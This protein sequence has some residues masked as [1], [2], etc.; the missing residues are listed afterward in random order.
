M[1]ITDP[2]SLAQDD[3]KICWKT[4]ASTSRLLLFLVFEKSIFNGELWLHCS[5]IP[6]SWVLGLMYLCVCVCVVLLSV[7]VRSC[8]VWRK[9]DT[10]R[11]R[12]KKAVRV[13]DTRADAANEK[14]QWSRL[15]EKGHNPRQP[16]IAFQ[17]KNVPWLPQA[18]STQKKK[19]NVLDTHHFSLCL[20]LMSTPL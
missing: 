13:E 10:R 14:K 8:T 11:Q 15:N 9:N 2:P 16:L 7:S 18:T 1:S 4:I 17:E 5:S 3:I 12:K 19:E 20:R 6:T